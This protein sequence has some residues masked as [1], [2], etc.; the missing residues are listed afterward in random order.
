MSLKERKEQ[1]VSGL[2]GGSIGEIY[3][4][5]TVPVVSYLA[6]RLFAVTEQDSFLIDFALNCLSCI[7]AVTVYSNVPIQL[8]TLILAP[9]LGY[10]IWNRKSVKLSLLVPLLLQTG[11][12]LPKKQFL[13]AYRSQ[14]LI[15]TNIS[16]LAVDFQ[17]FPRRLAK[18]ETWGTSMMDLGVGSF[19]FSMGLVSSRTILKNQLTTTGYTFNL[20]RYGQLILK[21]TKKALPLLVLGIVRL[22]SVKGLEYQEHVTEYGIHW[23]FFITLGFLPIFLAILDPFFHAFPRAFIA[24]AILLVYEFLLVKLNLLEIILT[25]EFRL[26]NFFTMNKEGICSFFGFL[27]IFIFGQLFGSFV[28]P[29]KPT[30]NSLLGQCGILRKSFKSLS[31]STFDGLLSLTLIYHL[32]FWFI[33]NSTEFHQVSR[34]IAN[35][36]YVMW[37]V[38]YNSTMLFVYNFIDKFFDDQKSSSSSSDP[39]ASPILD[40]TNKNGLALFLLANLGTGFVNMSINTID[41]PGYLAFGILVVYSLVLALVAI[42]LDRKGIYLKV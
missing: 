25:D 8:Q 19:V 17:I 31:V 14:M 36:A 9:A 11:A 28:L 12:T 7:T 34:R 22:L 24:L 20:S 27:S 21:S 16:I 4:I 33:S 38:S 1:F 5:T 23:N 30:P 10:Y 3:S 32:M 40:A 39:N 35:I 37:V 18:V 15:L 6:Y 29:S 13:T 41:A 26:Q 42:G 2:Y